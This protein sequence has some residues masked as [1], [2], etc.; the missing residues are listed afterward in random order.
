M[1]KQSII[2]GILGV[3]LSVFA[4]AAVSQIVT[5]AKSSPAAIAD[6]TITPENVEEQKAALEAVDPADLQDGMTHDGVTLYHDEDSNLY[7]YDKSGK[8]IGLTKFA[9][10]DDASLPKLDEAAL[11]DYAEQYLGGLVA[12]P[13]RYTLEEFRADNGTYTAYWMARC[14]GY[15]TTD[16][17]SITMNPTGTLQGYQMH[18]TGDFADV[19]VTEAQITEAIARAEAE[20]SS[21]DAVITKID[22]ADEVVLTHDESGRLLLNVGVSREVTSG[23]L[24]FTD[25]NISQVPVL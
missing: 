23:E 24:T 13:A 20:A 14:C 1:K 25:A 17:V 3:T 18:H 6:K 4:V 8:L 2:Y 11:R 5:S 7:R 12:D 15:Q 16:I 22:S 19:T 9:D 21:P 10:Q